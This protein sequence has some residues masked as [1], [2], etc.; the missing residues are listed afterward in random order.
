M[1]RPGDGQAIAAGV[2]AGIVGFAGAFA[3]VLSGLRGVGASP[4]EAASGL[5][6][7]LVLMGVGSIA[8]ALRTRMP[9]AVAWSTPG[10]ALVA[11]SQGLSMEEAVGA[12]V[13]AGLLIAVLGL[14]RPLG[15]LVALIPDAIAAGMLAGVLLPFCLRLA[16]AA[17]EASAAT[18][19]TDATDE[20]KA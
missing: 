11:A 20:S 18:E 17:A 16:P 3:V 15:R 6:A 9:V 2:V 4:A 19:G 14:V 1:I 8:L 5:M 10:A 12:F 7:L 13:L